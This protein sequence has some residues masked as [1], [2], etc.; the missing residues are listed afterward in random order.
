[1]KTLLALLF[2]GTL[3]ASEPSIIKYNLLG[4]TPY[5]NGVLGVEWDLN[6]DDAED[7]KVL[8]Y[9]KLCDGGVCTN[10]KPWS[11]WMDLNFDGIYQDNEKFMYTS[12]NDKKTSK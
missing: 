3:T 8:Y 1:M 9:Y 11:Y 4:F 10:P 7:L 12:H 2:A 6:G 5:P